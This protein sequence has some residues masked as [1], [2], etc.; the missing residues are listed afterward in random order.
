MKIDFRR[1]DLIYGLIIV[2]SVFVIIAFTIIFMSIV[3]TY[4]CPYCKHELMNH[5][6]E[7]YCSECGHKLDSVELYNSF[8][9]PKNK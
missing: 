6:T 8:N 4:H 9:K 7:K 1:D 2:S 3:P 5:N